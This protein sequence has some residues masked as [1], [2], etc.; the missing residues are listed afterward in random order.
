MHAIQ[1]FIMQRVKVLLNEEKTV[2]ETVEV[3]DFDYP[4]HFSRQFKSYFGVSPKQFLQNDGILIT[5]FIIDVYLFIK[6]PL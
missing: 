6:V 2:S 3:P 4:Q 1:R 5:F